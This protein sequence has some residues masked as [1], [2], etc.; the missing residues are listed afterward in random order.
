M[1][2]IAITAIAIARTAAADPPLDH[3]VTAPTAWLPAD[4]TAYG[5]ASLDHRGETAIDLGYALGGLAEVELG[6]DHDVRACE[7]SCTPILEERAAFR[8][9]AHQ[10]AWFAGMPAIALGVRA[11]IGTPARRVGEAYLVASRVLAFARVH[12]GVEAIDAGDG[13]SRPG[14]VVRPLA[15][16][17]LVPPQY[18]KTTVVGDIA[19]L[20]RFGGAPG[21]EWIA[22]WGVRYQALRWGSIELDVRHREGE[23]LAQSTVMVRVNGV[24]AR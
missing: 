22:G 13:A 5:S 6:A 3:V 20:A 19:W 24:W 2:R 17:E 23:G 7:P 21:T 15:A 9:G 14:V 12:A 4:G 1:R 8:L 10:D 16:L 18:P 11:T